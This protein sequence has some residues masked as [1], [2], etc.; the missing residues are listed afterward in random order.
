MTEIEQHKSQDVAEYEQELSPLGRWALDASQAYRVA[1]SLAETSFVPASMRKRPG[2][3]TAAILTGQEL[4][5]QP[6]SALRS[7][8]VIQGTPAMRAVALRGLVQ[9]RGHEVWV[10]EQTDTR[11]VVEGRRRGTEQVQRSVWTIDRAK[12]MGLTSKQNWQTQPQA[13]LVARAT[14][15]VCRLIASDVIMG[16][17]YAAEELDAD[18]D[19]QET[20]KSPEKRK[21]ARRKPVET[22]EPDLSEPEPEE[23][24]P[25]VTADEPELDEPDE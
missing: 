7:I 17:P 2:E 22:A 25:V 3:I 16:A 13:M 12:K 14:A 4:G 5:L 10:K 11:A 9:S 6:M 19:Y 15:E 18:A 23:A 8:D 1:Q 24:P 21:V 20:P